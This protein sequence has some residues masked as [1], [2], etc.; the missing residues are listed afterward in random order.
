MYFTPGVRP[1]DVCS[2][3]D[4]WQASLRRA[5]NEQIE[6]AQ[7]SER[8]ARLA[9]QRIVRRAGCTSAARL[10]LHVAGSVFVQSGI[11]VGLAD[12]LVSE[13]AG[14]GSYSRTELVWWF[15]GAGWFCF[16][17]W[18]AS[19]CGGEHSSEWAKS[20]YVWTID[21]CFTNY[22]AGLWGSFW[23]VSPFYWLAC[24]LTGLFVGTL[25]TSTPSV[26]RAA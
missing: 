8:L 26:A 16:L 22:K 3:S 23:L 19:E 4:A 11:W 20:R 6:A 15:E 18:L 9:G 14:G 7:E 13:T 17:G 24:V 10:G 12:G 5:E 25:L 1:C 2:E 21:S